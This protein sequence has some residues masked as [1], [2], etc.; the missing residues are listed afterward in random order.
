VSSTFD[1]SPALV[2]RH[3]FSGPARAVLCLAASQ[4]RNLPRLL[5]PRVH[6]VRSKRGAFSPRHLRHTHTARALS[7]R[8]QTPSTRHL[9]TSPRLVHSR[10]T[11]ASRLTTTRFITH[12]LSRHSLSAPSLGA[13]SGC[14]CNA[15]LYSSSYP[16]QPSYTRFKEGATRS[17]T[18]IAPA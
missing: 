16:F 9:S 14:C 3:L 18:L 15:A 8:L 6:R 5:V 1:S 2:H 12:F 13:A 10:T 17:I 7:S 11:T 4:S